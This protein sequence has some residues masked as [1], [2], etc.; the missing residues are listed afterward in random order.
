VSHIAI[1]GSADAG[2]ASDSAHGGGSVSATGMWTFLAADAMGF[3]GL[4]AAYAVLRARAA[5]GAWP[6]PRSRLALAPAVAMTFALLTSS[7]TM[8]LA[9]RAPGVRERRRWLLATLAL[10]VAFLAGAAIEYGHLL[11][12][13]SMGLATDV[14]ASTFYVITGFHGLH[15]LAGVIGIG[16]MLRAKH[17]AQAIETMGLYWH[18]VDVA[19]M[20]IFSVIY[21]WPVR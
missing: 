17:G 13:A 2:A 18:F 20:P 12:G 5:A 16:F 11:G 15:V 4:L 14:F 1:D 10:G 21:L 6:D 9:M 3:G 19:W 7:L 8:T